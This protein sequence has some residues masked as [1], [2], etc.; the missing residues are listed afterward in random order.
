MNQTPLTRIL[1]A[2]VIVA[3]QVLIFNH[4]HILG[5]ATPLVC[6]YILMT[7]PL[8][9]P[10]YSKLLWGFGIGLVQ[11]AFANTPGVMAA[12]LTF[13]AFIQGTL[14]EFFGG[15]DS[16]DDGDE[17]PSTKTLGLYFFLRYA[18]V[19]V[20]IQTAVFYLLMTFNFF[21]PLDT[22]INIAGSSVLS[23]L[24]I[25]FMESIRSRSRK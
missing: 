22:A 2:I 25:W 21:N 23:F 1:F 13:M 5:Y 15:Q 4:V 9:M 18:A 11:D 24:A 12:T 20:L 10:K 17:V 19:S 8:S 3:L 14:L 16:D 6:V 7:F